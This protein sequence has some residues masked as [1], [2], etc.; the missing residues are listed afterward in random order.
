MKEEEGRRF[1]FERERE[2]EEI[3]K[4]KRIIERGGEWKGGGWGLR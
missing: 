2:R 1:G 3:D 4:N